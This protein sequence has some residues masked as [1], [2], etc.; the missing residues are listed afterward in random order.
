[1]AD[2]DFNFGTAGTSGDSTPTPPPVASLSP[3]TSE[4]D[5]KTLLDQLMTEVQ[6]DVSRG[7]ITKKVPARPSIS[8]RFNPNLDKA[9]LEAWAR[10]CGSESKRGLDVIKYSTMI[11]AHTC[12]AILINGQEVTDDGYPITFGSDKFLA[13][14]DGLAPIPHGIRAFYGNDAHIEALGLVIVQAAGFG[15]DIEDDEDPT[16]A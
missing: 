8:V 14:V 10:K 7:P 15:E 2:D 9:Q 3:T 11:I 6:K 16:Q 4:V 12:E 5:E 1:M 13:M